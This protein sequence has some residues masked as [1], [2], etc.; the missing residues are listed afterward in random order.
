MPIAE[1]EGALDR[2]FELHGS[3]V[4]DGTGKPWGT[5]TGDDLVEAGASRGDRGC[6][7][8]LHAPGSCLRREPLAQI[9]CL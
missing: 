5:D 3:G 1:G 2:A 8:Q 9:L 7:R 6:L 4:G